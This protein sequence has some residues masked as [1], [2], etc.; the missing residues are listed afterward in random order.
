MKK[1]TM[2]EV[3]KYLKLR[4][5]T[6]G[7]IIQ[8]YESLERDRGFMKTDDM[9]SYQIATSQLNELERLVTFIEGK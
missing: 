7:S 5:Q 9:V 1:R 4:S 6:L 2:T 3:L 8:Y